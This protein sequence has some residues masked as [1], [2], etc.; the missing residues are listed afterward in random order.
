MFEW[1]LNCNNYN[2]ICMD[3]VDKLDE[4]ALSHLQWPNQSMQNFHCCDSVASVFWS[5]TWLNTFFHMTY[6]C[7][8]WWAMNANPNVSPDSIVSSIQK[9]Y[10]IWGMINCWPVW[11]QLTIS[12]FGSAFELVELCLY[13]FD[14]VTMNQA[15]EPSNTFFSP[16]PWISVQP[17]FSSVSAFSF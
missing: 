11:L 4:L 3:S 13:E 8:S 16:F 12:S 17:C 9:P 1:V 10:C 7:I 6:I 15:S 14:A 2:I 5:W